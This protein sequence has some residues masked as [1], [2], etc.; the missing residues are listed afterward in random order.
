MRP[1]GAVLGRRRRWCGRSLQ[2][3]FVD[4][5][6]DTLAELPADSRTN[7]RTRQRTGPPKGLAGQPRSP[8]RQES[9]TAQLLER[10]TDITGTRTNPQ[11]R[12]HIR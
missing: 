7:Y 11:H 8:V 12:D 3:S 2:P 1:G 6:I 4:I 5:E 9:H 10:R